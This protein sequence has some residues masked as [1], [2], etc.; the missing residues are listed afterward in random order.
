MESSLQRCDM[1]TNN[2]DLEY[3]EIL[4][5]YVKFKIHIISK[6]VFSIYLKKNEIFKDYDS[7][8]ER[9]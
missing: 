8:N 9:R 1:S 4:H 5:N 6:E 3:K 7:F 2:L